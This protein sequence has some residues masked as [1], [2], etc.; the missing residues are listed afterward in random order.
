M[1]NHPAPN[2]KNI[3]GS[4][5]N[6]NSLVEI[7]DV[8][9]TTTFERKQLIYERMHD[10]GILKTLKEHRILFLVSS[11]SKHPTGGDLVYGEAVVIGRKKA[12]DQCSQILYEHLNNDTKSNYLP[13][14]TIL[15]QAEHE[16]R[17]T[18]NRLGLKPR[19]RDLKGALKTS[20]TSR[21]EITE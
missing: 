16:L 18:F 3:K 11:G 9:N 5:Q 2:P 8:T 21:E 6:L 12:V 15:T 19:N 20:F 7:V 17:R 10:S 13:K 4:E 1:Y 14:S